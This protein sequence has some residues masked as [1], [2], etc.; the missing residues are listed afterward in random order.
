M[1]RTQTSIWVILCLVDVHDSVLQTKNLSCPFQFAFITVWTDGILVCSL[2]PKTEVMSLLDSAAISKNTLFVSWTPA[3]G[4]VNVF[5]LEFID[6]VN[7]LAL[8]LIY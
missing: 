3:A 5:G 1:A 4:L 2:S 8:H 6:Y 7:T